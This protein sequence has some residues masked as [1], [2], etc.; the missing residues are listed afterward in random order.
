MDFLKSITGKL[1]TGG[2]IL[3]TFA[4]GLAWYQTDPATRS[5]MAG[6]AGRIVG[7]I[8]G[9]ASIP[10]LL[11]FLIQSIAKR[12]SN[13]ASGLFVVAVTAIEAVA[14]AWLFHFAI[15]GGAGWTFFI[16][17][18]LLAGVY[19]LLVCDWLAERFA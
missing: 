12:D 17:G 14:L 7:W 3:A 5:A 6:G 10:W 2:V 15:V 18:I 9:V 16:V 19:N 4:A 1:V 8:V 13:L 11:I